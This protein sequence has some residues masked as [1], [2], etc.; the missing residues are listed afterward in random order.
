MTHQPNKAQ[1]I[2][3]TVFLSLPDLKKIGIGLVI[4]TLGFGGMYGMLLNQTVLNIVAREE[5]ERKL[6][7]LDMGLSEYEFKYITATSH[8]TL[9]DVLALGYVEDLSPTFVSPSEATR[10]TYQR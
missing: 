2:V 6:A 4:L 3:T 9:D 10:F 7:E 5:G 1:Q 8:V